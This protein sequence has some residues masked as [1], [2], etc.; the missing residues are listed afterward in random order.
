MKEW[1]KDKGGVKERRGS[2]AK[3]ERSNKIKKGKK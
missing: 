2:I 3:G 1:G